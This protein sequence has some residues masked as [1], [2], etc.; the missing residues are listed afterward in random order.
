M[1]IQLCLDSK[2]LNTIITKYNFNS[3]PYNKYTLK[4]SGNF[5]LIWLSE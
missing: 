4:K 5:I 3:N 2:I 1:E